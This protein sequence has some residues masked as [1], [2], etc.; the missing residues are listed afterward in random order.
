MDENYSAGSVIS[1]SQTA[2]VG[3]FGMDAEVG[4]NDDYPSYFFYMKFQP[5]DDFCAT[6]TARTFRMLFQM[7]NGSSNWTGVRWANDQTASS[8]GIYALNQSSLQN[9]KLSSVNESEKDNSTFYGEIDC[10]NN[11]ITIL[12]LIERDEQTNTDE[13]I[14][15]IEKGRVLSGKYWDLT[16]SMVDFEITLQGAVSGLVM[17]A[18]ALT[19]SVTLLSF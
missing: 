17:A 5:A 15:R 8:P 12:R 16:S 18:S 9:D 6:T 1:D 10:G 3:M 13:S 19:A 2:T 7:G 4:F 11:E 14:I